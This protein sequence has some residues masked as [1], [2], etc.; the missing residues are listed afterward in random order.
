MSTVANEI[1]LEVLAEDIFEDLAKSFRDL[2]YSDECII[3]EV[4]RDLA[5]NQL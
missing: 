4:A 3:M 5:K 1:R 2:D